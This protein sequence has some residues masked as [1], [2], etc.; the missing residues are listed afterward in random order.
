MK[1]TFEEFLKNNHVRED[2]DVDFATYYYKL[3]NQKN[4]L[5]KD[6]YKAVDISRQTYSKIISGKI[7]PSL[8]MA[9]RIAIGLKCT[10]DEC[11]LLLKKF[12]YTLPSSSKFAL[13]IRYCLENNIYDYN[14]INSILYEEN[15]SLLDE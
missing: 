5:D 11:K 7:K 13:V 4:L 14:E 15:L 12:E 3:L 6:V 1:Q 8:K 10:N 2:H 9:V